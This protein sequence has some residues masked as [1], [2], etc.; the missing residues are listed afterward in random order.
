MNTVVEI[1]NVFPKLSM[2]ESSFEI[3]QKASLF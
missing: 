1:K 3:Y 2:N